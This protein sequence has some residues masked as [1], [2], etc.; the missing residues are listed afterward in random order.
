MAD[1]R[2]AK[3]AAGAAETVPCAPEA[4]FVFD[5]PATDATL[6]RDGDN[7]AIQF[8]DGSRLNLEGFYTEYNEENL[9]SFSID[10]T[11]V[12]A[13]DFFAAMN[14]PDLMPAA[15]PGAGTTPTGGRFHEWGDASLAAGIDHLNGLD[16]GFSRSFEWEDHPN[17]VGGGDDEGALFARGPVNTVPGIEVPVPG[18]PEP[19]PDTPGNSSPYIP[20][21]NDAAIV[22]DEGALEGKGSGL[23]KGHGAKGTGDF[24]AD[25]HDEAGGSI[26]LSFGETTVRLEIPRDGTPRID[27]PEG[28]PT[29]T[30]NGV[31]IAINGAVSDGNG[32]WTVNYSYE[33]KSSIYH[34]AEKEEGQAKFDSGIA[35]TVTDGSGDVAEGRLS[36]EVH[37][38][39][40]VITV[41]APHAESDHAYTLTGTGSF[42]F[43]ADDAWSEQA[44]T[45]DGSSSQ[46]LTV[47]M[48]RGGK[49]FTA[50]VNEPS[51]DGTF[52][53]ELGEGAGAITLTPQPDT[54]GQFSFTYTTPQDSPL[55]SSSTEL[56]YTFDFKITDVDGDKATAQVGCTIRPTDMTVIPTPETPD[57]PFEADINNIVIGSTTEGLQPATNYNM[58]FLFDLAGSSSVKHVSSQPDKNWVPDTVEKKFTYIDFSG[59]ETPIQTYTQTDESNTEQH[60][61]LLGTNDGNN[62]QYYDI[63]ELYNAT[64]NT[65]EYIKSVMDTTSGNGIPPDSTVHVLLAGFDLKIESAMEFTITRDGSD[66]PT[67]LVRPFESQTLKLK[68]TGEK[69][70]LGVSVGSA[71]EAL[72]SQPKEGPTGAEV[73]AWLDGIFTKFMSTALYNLNSAFSNSDCAYTYAGTNID[74]ALGLANGW[75]QNLPNPDGLPSDQVVNKTFLLSDGGPTAHNKPVPE[76]FLEYYNAFAGKGGNNFAYNVYAITDYWIGDTNGDWASSVLGTG[77]ANPTWADVAWKPGQVALVKLDNGNEGTNYLVINQLGLVCGTTVTPTSE[78]TAA[79]QLK[80]S[81]SDGTGYQTSIPVVMDWVQ[82][83]GYFG[84]CLATGNTYHN[85]PGGNNNTMSDADALGGISDIVEGTNKGANDLKEISSLTVIKFGDANLGGDL[86]GYAST[87]TGGAA[88]KI[89]M[90]QD[91][92]Q[93]LPEYINSHLPHAVDDVVASGA[94]DDILF[95]DAIAPGEAFL[96]AEKKFDS[97]CVESANVAALAALAGLGEDANANPAKIAAKIW[98]NSDEIAGE[99]DRDDS[100][101]GGS[102]TLIGGADNDLLY[103]MNGN[104]VLFGDGDNTSPEQLAGI[105]GSLQKGNVDAKADALVTAMKEITGENSQKFDLLGKAIDEK[106]SDDAEKDG[107]DKL[108]GGN[109]DDVLLGMGGDDRLMGGAGDDYLFGGAGNDY[110]D[111]GAGKDYLN[112]GAGS[113]LLVYDAED[114]LIDGGNNIDFLLT[115]KDNVSLGTLEN[116]RNVEILLKGEGAMSLTR[117]EELAEKYGI[118]MSADGNSLT[119]T[120]GETNG[121]TAKDDGT[122]IHHDENGEVDLTMETANLTVRESDSDEAAQAAQTL[123]LSAQG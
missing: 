73:N 26:E 45:P 30:V 57:T 110:L 60:Y 83:K 89:I 21:T 90:G 82:D 3:P 55:N 91:T 24:V 80:Y 112:G 49:T 20:N 118:E 42:N 102:D 95:G 104:D 38:D 122:Y 50:T 31:E 92:W 77:L 106:F 36:V 97:G 58:A 19:G 65:I 56:D 15:G 10:G 5:F 28:T 62:T 46:S 25:V 117:M 40:P 121:W 33:L 120:M 74:N 54:N 37:D 39:G 114:Y 22:V 18:E 88:D 35:I 4:R 41:D 17:A 27:L 101:P 66:A 99:L 1:I 108:Y 8:E 81:Y 103:G 48:T 59:T 67:I 119:L 76:G 6:A 63:T 61:A 79:S 105:I 47:T 116:V 109:G 100:N 113:D 69:V 44:A 71:G 70:T 68:D 64:Q 23:H 75:F 43:G 98:N 13:A 123:T 111:G 94:G 7:L 93:F 72:F 115:D 107:N 11:E 51:A 52:T 2:L 87:T 12:A 85:G 84:P 53:F 96:N 32:K 78:L 29:F 34:D 86:D 16:W 9:P 14:E